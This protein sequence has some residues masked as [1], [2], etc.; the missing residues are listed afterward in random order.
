M[1]YRKHAFPKKSE[2]EAN[3]MK[4]FVPQNALKKLLNFS[5][6]NPNSRDWFEEGEK[7]W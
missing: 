5:K 6:E 4:S 2:I 7:K 3:L 1:S